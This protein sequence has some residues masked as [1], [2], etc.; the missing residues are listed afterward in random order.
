LALGYADIDNFKPFNDIYGFSRGDD[1][2]RMTGR[3]I[4]NIVKQRQPEKSFV[5]HIGGDDFIFVVDP[6]VA[7]GAASEI[8]RSFDQI[9]PLFYNERERTNG[10][11][12]ATDRH[13]HRRTFPVMALSIGITSNEYRPFTHFG[14]IST[15]ATELKQFAK[16]EKGSCFKI[17][18]RRLGPE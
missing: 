17:D 9:V 8:I 15:V 10:T 11:I 12:E 7:E 5:G 14:E 13:G 1:V 3:I 2:I 6:G 18:R 4:F 16:K